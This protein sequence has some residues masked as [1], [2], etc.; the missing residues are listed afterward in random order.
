MTSK[1]KN[2]M[3]EKIKIS[4]RISILSVFTILLMAAGAIITLIDYYTTENI[5]HLISNKV[6][7]QS[8]VLTE[9]FVIQ[10]FHYGFELADQS[11]AI[12]HEGIVTPRPTK[13][14]SS[15][16]L[17]AISNLPSNMMISWGDPAG[18]YYGIV[19]SSNNTFLN[20]FITCKKDIC[21]AQT[22]YLNSENNIISNIELSSWNQKTKKIISGSFTPFDPRTRI[23][24]QEAVAKHQPIL[25]DVFLANKFDG[26]TVLSMNSANPVYTPNGQLLGVFAVKTSLQD[27]SKYLASINITKHSVIFIIDNNGNLIA[28]KNL[29]N[30][31]STTLPKIDALNLSWINPSYQHFKDTHET[32]FTYKFNKTEYLALYQ[33]IPNLRKKHLYIGIALP[34]KDIVGLLEH[35]LLTSLLIMLLVLSIAAFLIWYIAKSISKPII[36]LANEVKNVIYSISIPMKHIKSRIKEIIYMQDAFSSMK[37]SL[38]SFTRY[39][40]FNLV[41]LLLSQGNIAH[42]GGESKELTCLFADIQG[43]T[44]LS[45]KLTPSQLMIYLSE[46]FDV[47]TKI[48]LK[49]EGTVDK[50]IG[51]CVMAFWGAPLDD[52]KHAFHACT[53]ALQMQEAL[54]ELNRNW[55]SQGQPQLKVRIGINTGKMIVG[56]VGSDDRINYTILGDNVNLA[57]SAEA[58]NKEYGTNIIITDHTY[59]FVKNDFTTRLLDFFVF[60]DTNEGINIYELKATSKKQ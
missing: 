52:N 55:S 59:Q 16:L 17:E 33:V 21:T 46:Y 57:N 47:M 10:L 34:V 5:L 37:Q 6:L 29:Q 14:Y 54:I 20:I 31:S 36:K 12:I 27:L 15:F 18:N 8:S 30:Y 43:F 44:T 7:Q 38:Q 1:T 28:A 58:I 40:P 19:R 26:S 11:A 53:A 51:D 25:T 23:W 4:V 3:F 22:K 56:N 13:N 49:N 50:Y 45:E 35:Q 60:S 48:I 41:K 39:V 9:N 24:Y 32:F 42:V 2:S